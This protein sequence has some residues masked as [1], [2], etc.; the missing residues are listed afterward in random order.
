VFPPVPKLPKPFGRGCACVNP[1][2]DVV[3]GDF[4]FMIDCTLGDVRVGFWS[5]SVQPATSP[6]LKNN[7]TP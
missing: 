6:I 4:P 7:P 3:V 2:P 5:L 1:V